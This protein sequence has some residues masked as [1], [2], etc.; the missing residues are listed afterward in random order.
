MAVAGGHTYQSISAAQHH[1]C[2]LSVQGSAFCWGID[3]NGEL[4]DGEMTSEKLTPV[5]VTGGMV[6]SA[7]DVGGGTT[8][9]LADGGAAYCWGVQT[10]GS[11]GN[12]SLGYEPSPVA[13]VGGLLLGGG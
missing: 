1:S 7:L 13:V 11:L 12:G 2:A 9:G 6:F 4:G 3:E 10:R 5:P 8:C